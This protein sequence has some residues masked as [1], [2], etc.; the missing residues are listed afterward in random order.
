MENKIILVAVI[1][2]VFISGCTQPEPTKDNRTAGNQNGATNNSNG[3][4]GSEEKTF[5]LTEVG[6]H[7]SAQDCWLTVNG[8]VYDVT[9]FISVHPGG[10][11]ILEGCG[12]DATQLFES[13]PMGSGTPHSDNAKNLMKNYYIG[14]LK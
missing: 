9:D 6:L 13:R 3:T 4:N 14:E 5:S 1:L 8:K 7:N 11:A 12:K 10:Q 2:L